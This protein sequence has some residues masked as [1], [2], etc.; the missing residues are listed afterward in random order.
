MFLND[1]LSVFRRDIFIPGAFRVDDADRSVAA[2]AKALALRAI[3]GTVGPRN[4]ELLHA[5]LEVDPRPL[6]IFEIG[7]VRAQANEEVTRQASNPKSTSCFRRRVRSLGHPIDDTAVAL[8]LLRRVVTRKECS[9]P[10]ETW[11]GRAAT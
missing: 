9:W 11:A 6:A 7:A 10:T 8:A 4:V 2:D 3:E 1:A 5:P